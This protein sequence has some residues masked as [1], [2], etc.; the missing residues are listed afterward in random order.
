MK[1]WDR[2]STSLK[3]DKNTLITQS[4]AEDGARELAPDKE[5][6]S[7]HEACSDVP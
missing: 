3:Q 6:E 7:A 4:T 1:G 5:A 2:L